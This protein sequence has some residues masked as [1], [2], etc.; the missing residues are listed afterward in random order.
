MTA[1]LETRASITATGDHCHA[2]ELARHEALLP[3]GLPSAG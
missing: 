3:P 2:A 1:L